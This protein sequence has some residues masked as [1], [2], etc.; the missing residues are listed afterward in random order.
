MR[1]DNQYLK[2]RRGL[3]EE[4]RV[5]ERCSVSWSLKLRRGLKGANIYVPRQMWVVHL[6]LRRGLKESNAIAH[7]AFPL[8]FLNSE[9]D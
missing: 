8:N 6:K 5:E 7:A 2:L 4:N 1:F 3:K 9:E